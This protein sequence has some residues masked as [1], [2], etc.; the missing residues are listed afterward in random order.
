LGIQAHRPAS[1]DFASP[2]F[3]ENQ[4]PSLTL[5]CKARNSASASQSKLLATTAQGMPVMRQS[6]FSVQDPSVGTK[7][8]IM[9]NQQAPS[10]YSNQI[11]DE[12]AKMIQFK[13]LP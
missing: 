10:L 4:V 9:S 5:A 12:G 7:T 2:R 11:L 1:D 8:S 3:K 13:I 6:S